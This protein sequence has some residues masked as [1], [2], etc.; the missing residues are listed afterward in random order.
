MRRELRAQRPRLRIAVAVPRI[1]RHQ[2][3]NQS[4][5]GILRRTICL[6]PRSCHRLH[7]TMHRHRRS[8]VLEWVVLHERNFGKRGERFHAL[9]FVLNRALDQRHWDA[10]GR[11][12]GKIRHERFRRWTLRHGLGDGEVEGRGDAPGIACATRC[13]VNEARS[14]LCIVGEAHL[15]ALAVGRRM[16]ES[17]R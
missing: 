8:A 7:E 10:L 6:R 15:R 1:D 2:P 14:L 12:L 16:V 5:D 9:R 4:P 17:E 3:C 13:C 11:A